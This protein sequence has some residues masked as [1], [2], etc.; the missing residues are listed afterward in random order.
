V[1]FFN[2][3]TRAVLS[4]VAVAINGRP[5]GFGIETQA[6]EVDI[7]LNSARGS[8]R[9]RV[10]EAMLC[11]RVVDADADGGAFLLSG[12]L[13]IRSLRLFYFFVHGPGRL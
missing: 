2:E 1:K 10:G 3:Y 12:S 4:E 13:A 9:R 7:G 6:L 8:I 11:W 5:L